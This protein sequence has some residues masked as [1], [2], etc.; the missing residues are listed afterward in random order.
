MKIIIP[1]FDFGREGGYRVLSNLATEWGK[2]NEV[3]FL[4]FSTSKEPYFPTKANIVRLSNENQGSLIQKIIILNKYLREQSKDTI[5]VGNQNLTTWPLLFL[6]NKNIF[7]YIQAY[8]PEFYN[9]YKKSIYKKYILKFT[10]WLTYFLPLKRVVNAELYLNYKN[11]KSKHVV[12]PGLNLD[13]YYPKELNKENKKELI[14]GCIGRVEEWKGAQDVGRAVEILHRKGLPIK[15]KVAFNAVKYKNHE[16]VK[17][18]GDNSLADY[19]RSLDI[20]VAPGHIQLGAIHYPVIEAMA[21]NVPVITTGYYPANNENSFIVPIKSPE[22]IAKKIEEIYYDYEKAY[23]KTLVAQKQIKEFSWEIVGNKF[24][25][26]IR[27][28]GE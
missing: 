26:I 1:V 18:N 14:V 16:L 2:E 7:Y 3:E 13:I 24:L 27:E 11:I 8:E 19:Y 5:I 25:D 9:E 28:E 15:L 12:P 20:L 23:E 4:T 21:C 17:P 22:E 6:K 10:A